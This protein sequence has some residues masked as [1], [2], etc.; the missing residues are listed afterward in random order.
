MTTKSPKILDLDALVQEQIIVRLN[1]R[2]HELRHVT[3]KDFLENA[4]D[5]ETMGKSPSLEDEIKITKRMLS[6]AFPSMKEADFDG[7]NMVQ[8]Q[9]IIDYAHSNNGQ[10]AGQVAAAEEAAANPPTAA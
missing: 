2:D 10:N 4:K 9:A 6:R 3:L 5:I 7:L 8:M 1:G